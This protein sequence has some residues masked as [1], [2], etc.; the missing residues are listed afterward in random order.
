MNGKFFPLYVGASCK[1]LTTVLKF[2]Y[3]W[4][5]ERQYGTTGEF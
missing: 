1:S 4:A 2:E 5:F 3:L